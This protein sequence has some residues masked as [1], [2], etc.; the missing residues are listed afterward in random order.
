MAIDRN[1]NF[2]MRDGEFTSDTT[3]T[4]GFVGGSPVGLNNYGYVSGNISVTGVPN[5]IGCAW[6][7]SV[8]DL[9]GDGMS[10]V[11][12][13][14]AKIK[15]VADAT[16]IT[17]P[18]KGSLTYGPDLAHCWLRPTTVTVGSVTTVSVWTNEALSTVGAYYARI[19]ELEGTT[20]TPTSLTIVLGYFPSL[21]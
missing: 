14:P 21:T 15:L 1:I 11:I 16:E 18:W 9:A 12:Y 8:D 2:V 10:T 7:S 5:Y 13:P 4:Q 6:H 17:N 20:T 19:V 3:A